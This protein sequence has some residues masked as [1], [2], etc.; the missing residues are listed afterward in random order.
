M[1]VKSKKYEERLLIL[2]T[3]LQLQFSLF[4]P[5]LHLFGLWCLLNVFFCMTPFL[6]SDFFCWFKEAPGLGSENV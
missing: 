4:G 1:Y 3:H 6:V 2:L 5:S